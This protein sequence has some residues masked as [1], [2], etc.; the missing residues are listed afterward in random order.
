M[1]DVQTPKKNIPKNLQNYNLSTH[2]KYQIIQ[3]INLVIKKSIKRDKLK[4]ILKNT[5]KIYLQC[6]DTYPRAI[7]KYTQKIFR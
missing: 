7:L 6:S 4:N 3:N 5:W 2:S 1:N